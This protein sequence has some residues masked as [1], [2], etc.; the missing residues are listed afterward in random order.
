MPGGAR[1]A[2]PCRCGGR[3]L[4]G[5]AARATAVVHTWKVGRRQRS[6]RRGRAARRACAKGRLAAIRH[7]RK[8]G[9]GRHLHLREGA[10]KL[11]TVVHGERN[12]LWYQFGMGNPKAL[13][14]FHGLE[15]WNG[16]QPD[17]F[18]NLYKF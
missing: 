14:A 12:W 5:R 3:G 8:A 1:Q 9:G 7:W 4:V 17:Y 18:F 15:P 6:T 16:S 10:E 11:A 2:A 13:F